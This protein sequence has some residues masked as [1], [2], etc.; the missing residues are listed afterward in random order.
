LP[1]A[2]KRPRDAGGPP[3]RFEHVWKKFQRG[4]NY[5]S[6]RD[7]VPALVRRMTSGRP[8]PL[9]LE[10]EEFWALRDVSF[11]VEAGKAF[12]I[13]GGN[14]AGK[15]TTL[16]LLTKILKPTVGH[17]HVRGR[18][19]ALIEVAAGFHPDLTGRENI[20]LQGAIMG[21]KRAEIAKKLDEIIDFAGTEAFIDTPVK[22]YSSGMNARLGFSIAAHLDPDVL[23]IDEVLSVGDI[24]FQ[25][26]CVDRM[27]SY[28]RDGVAIVFVSHNM[29]AVT[30]LCENSLHLHQ[31]VQAIGPTEDVIQ[32][33]VTAVGTAKGLQVEGTT[34]IASAT[35]L[36]AQ[37]EPTTTADP[38][39]PLTLRTKIEGFPG[40]TNAE[41][42]FLA[43]RTMDRL[44]VSCAVFQGQELGLGTSGRDVT[45]DF[46]FNAN[47]GKGQ[48]YL[49]VGIWDI[50]NQQHLA[51]L[52]PAAM[53]TI[54]D[55]GSQL[56]IAALGV[57]GKRVS[58]KMQR[59]ASAG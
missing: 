41:V 39:E 10:R 32:T 20:F 58:E 50:D 14:G 52:T 27:K 49:E 26:R 8:D 4:E 38:G 3:V 6:L 51:I 37:Q 45:V 19:G 22:R 59:W 5:D 35:L 15:S 17:C 2:S 34:R 53:L 43:Y 16:K 40:G 28:K 21:M 42:G 13:I 55:L 44:M 31:S 24:A 12:G 36:N 18:V 57:S 11:E 25:Q 23:I 30:D 7:L 56:G 47:L 1:S 54:T 33:Y 46:A 9:A 29:H 48:Y